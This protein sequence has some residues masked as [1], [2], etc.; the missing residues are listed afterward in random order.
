MCENHEPVHVH[1]H[2]PTPE[3]VQGP[4]IKI[5][6]DTIEVRQPNGG[7]L[8]FTVDRPRCK[9]TW[10]ELQRRVGVL[11]ET[12][13][14]PFATRMETVF[15]NANL[16]ADEPTRHLAEQVGAT[17][18]GYKPGINFQACRKLLR[19]AVGKRW[20]EYL[21]TINVGQ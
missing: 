6:G 11:T 21:A 14:Q 3:P 12:G 7:L 20:E 4:V 15:Y 16:W 1:E 18:Q 17:L 2:A 19:A 9:K 10:Q 13:M 5:T 8:V